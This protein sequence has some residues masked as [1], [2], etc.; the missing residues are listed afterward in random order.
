MS[1]IDI[2]DWIVLCCEGRAV[3]CRVFS[4]L[5]CLYPLDARVSLLVVTT[6]NASSHCQL[7]PG[8]Q[9]RPRLR[10]VALDQ[11]NFIKCLKSFLSYEA[12]DGKLRL[13]ENQLKYFAL[14]SIAAKCIV[15]KTIKLT[16]LETGLFSFP[17]A[18]HNRV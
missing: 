12:A 13:I 8:G 9:N 17:F 6:K 14:I 5:P 4:S 11:D 16:C 1:P 10:T 3:Y 7:F 2:L 15:T 18:S